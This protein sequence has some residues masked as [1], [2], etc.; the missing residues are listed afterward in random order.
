MRNLWLKPSDAS[1]FKQISDDLGSVSS[2]QPYVGDILKILEFES[3]HRKK[4]KNA[5]SNLVTNDFKN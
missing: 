1:F 5:L 4:A 2:V 3:M